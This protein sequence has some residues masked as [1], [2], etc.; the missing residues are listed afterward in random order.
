[1]VWVFF[2]VLQFFSSSYYFMEILH[3]F[4]IN[5]FSYSSKRSNN[6]TLWKELFVL[7]KICYAK[8]T[9]TNSWNYRSYFPCLFYAVSQYYKKIWIL[10][11]PSSPLT[12]LFFSKQLFPLPPCLQACSSSLTYSNLIFSIWQLILWSAVWGSFMDMGTATCH[13]LYLPLV[14]VSVGDTEQTAFV[15]EHRLVFT[16]MELLSPMPTAHKMDKGLLCRTAN[17]HKKKYVPI[18]LE[19][20]VVFKKCQVL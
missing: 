3:T 13:C 5:I 18:H 1:M 16:A 19:S 20:K 11:H 15:H 8:M 9:R 17:I 12:N 4:P 6:F 2:L 10:W 14:A 7:F